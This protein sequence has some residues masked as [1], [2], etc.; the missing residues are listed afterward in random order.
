MSMRDELF[1]AKDDNSSLGESSTVAMTEEGG[2]D[3]AMIVITDDDLHRK[4]R[5]KGKVDG[6][7]S[8]KKLRLVT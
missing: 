4:V 8:K 3:S 2:G 7:Q 5:K 6:Y 1:T